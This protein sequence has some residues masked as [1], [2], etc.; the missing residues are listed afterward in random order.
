MSAPP[1]APSIRKATAND[2]AQLAVIARAAYAKY[3]P[4]LGREPPPMLADFPA[5]VS[6]GF[7][8]VIE[9]DGELVGY[10]IGWPEADAY[11]VDNIAVDVAWQ[12]RGL[13]RKLVD[14]A[15]AEA[16]RLNLPAVRLYTN[17]AMTENLAIYGH[18]GF[19]ETHRAI[20]NGL[21]RV[22]MRLTL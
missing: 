17:V 3:V 19:V 11:L 5:F 9:S 14:H 20:K 21:H 13:A 6:A 18:I 15:I 16:G 4:R 22:H 2:A 1:S 10:M 12:G 8:V 7:V